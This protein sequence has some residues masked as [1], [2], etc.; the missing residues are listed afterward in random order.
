MCFSLLGRLWLGRRHVLWCV[1]D[2]LCVV[3]VRVIETVDV[4]DVVLDVVDVIRF[5]SKM[6]TALAG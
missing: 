6:R 5:V 2:V 3:D 1:V 4:V